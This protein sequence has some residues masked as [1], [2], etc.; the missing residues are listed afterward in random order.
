MK[1]LYAFYGCLLLLASFISC[2][3]TAEDVIITNIAPDEA[4]IGEGIQLIGINF[5]A[6]KQDSGGVIR[7][8]FEGVE[9]NGF[10]NDDTS[11][12]VIVPA[13][14]K[15]GKVCIMHEGVKICSPIS[16][17]VV[18]GNPTSNSYMRLLDH[19]GNLNTVAVSVQ[20]GNNIYAGFVNWWKYDV[21]ANTWTSSP[22]PTD[23]VVRAMSFT[24]NGKGYLFGG[25]VMGGPHSNRLQVFDETTNSWS[26]ATPM[27]ANG[28]SD[29]AVFV[30]SN[31][32]YIAGGIDNDALGMN[33]VAQQLWE[34]N[35]ATDAWTR[36]ADLVYGIATG[37]YAVGI[38]NAF[39]FPG[40]G[41]LAQEYN[42]PTNT[43]RILAG[44]G[45]PQYAYPISDKQ[46]ELA[47]I[48][49]GKSNCSCPFGWVS[50]NS[51]Y[52]VGLNFD[53][54]QLLFETYNGLPPGGYTTMTSGVYQVIGDELYYG[55]GY[56]DPN[57]GI[58][59]KE[60]WRYRY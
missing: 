57:V 49:G 30:W 34:Y 14:A 13:G 48:V 56:N 24:I 4:R 17:N 22:A 58:Q 40:S 10:F 36:K 51:V 19:P 25:A 43:W 1:K 46:F 28:R 47:Y 33:T 42:P 41:L 31:K 37:S 39:Y 32:A 7:V 20:A 9:T 29:A 12:T 23:K 59:V 38:G 16:F 21:E 35:P 27:P 6:L 11:I 53:K 52:R 45:F 55:I 8:Y 15:D 60:W 18:S 2:S 54:T 26:F 50:N 44:N 3:K 5:N